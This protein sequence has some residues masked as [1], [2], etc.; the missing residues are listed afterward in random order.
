MVDLDN[1]APVGYSEM[2]RK[3]R[4]LKVIAVVLTIL[5]LLSVPIS[6]FGIVSAPELETDFFGPLL[7]V[8]VA[9]ICV[10]L[11][12]SSAISIATIWILHA[13]I[14]KRMEQGKKILPVVIAIVVAWAVPNIFSIIINAVSTLIENN[15]NHFI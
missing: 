15:L 3:V 10:V 9:T 12:I 5:S 2:K 13:V 14:K 1:I 4:I 8:F 11:L 7:P 6:V